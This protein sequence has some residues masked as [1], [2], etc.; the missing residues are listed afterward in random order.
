MVSARPGLAAGD[1]DAGH[2]NLCWSGSCGSTRK[3]L[4]KRVDAQTHQVWAFQK[5]TF[6]FVDVYKVLCKC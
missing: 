3:Q 1:R 5:P 2:E 4:L 6:A